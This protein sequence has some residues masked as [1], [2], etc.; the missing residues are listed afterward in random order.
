MHSRFLLEAARPSS[1][2]RVAKTIDAVTIDRT[3]SRVAP[4]VEIA[5]NDVIMAHSSKYWWD[6]LPWEWEVHY[7]D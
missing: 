3:T 2:A 4:K 5:I 7:L 6:L 1:C